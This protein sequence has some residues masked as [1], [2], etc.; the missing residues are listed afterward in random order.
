MVGKRQKRRRQLATGKLLGFSVIHSQG[1]G[2]NIHNEV[3]RGGTTECNHFE[4]L[5][6]C[7]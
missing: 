6:K 5:R 7:G 1:P 4:H 2:L 3:G